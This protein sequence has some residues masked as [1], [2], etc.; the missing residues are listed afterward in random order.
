[1]SSRV[2]AIRET[3]NAYQDAS[4]AE[5]ALG[6]MDLDVALLILNAESWQHDDLTRLGDYL[7]RRSA[8]PGQVDLMGEELK[9]LEKRDTELSWAEDFKLAS[10]VMLQ[11]TFPD[12]SSP[13]VPSIPNLLR[14]YAIIRIFNAAK[15]GINLEEYVRTTY[16]V[17]KLVTIRKRVEYSNETRNEAHNLK[18]KRNPNLISHSLADLSKRKR[19]RE[20]SGSDSDGS[21]FLHDYAVES[22]SDS[23]WHSSGEKATIFSRTRILLN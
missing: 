2:L 6:N 13:F 1:M 8:I 17:P 4:I 19:R 20:S 12:H 23:D 14:I 3:I 9:L 7:A 16:R 11:F 18:R 21:V 22:P 5:M 10:D 15:C